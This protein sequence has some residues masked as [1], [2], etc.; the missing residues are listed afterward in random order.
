MKQKGEYAQFTYG[1][2]ILKAMLG[3][4]DDEWDMVG[5]VDSD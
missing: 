1:E 4:I 5:Q 2:Y 3:A